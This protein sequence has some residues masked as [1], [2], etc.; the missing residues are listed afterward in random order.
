MGTL[1]LPLLFFGNVCDNFCEIFR[2]CCRAM[3]QIGSQKRP[4]NQR[5]SPNS[6][7][8]TPNENLSSS[9]AFL[10]K[11]LLKYEFRKP[12]S[13]YSC[14][15]LN[16]LI[17]ILTLRKFVGSVTRENPYQ[18]DIFS[19]RFSSKFSLCLQ[20]SPMLLLV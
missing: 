7:L 15:R 11:F 13:F 8:V 16:F 4:F 6:L 14:S 19:K 18:K 2:K 1:T 3:G 20:C 10:E 17:A 12:L 9:Q 5:E